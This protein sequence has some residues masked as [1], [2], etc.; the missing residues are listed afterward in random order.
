MSPRPIVVLKPQATAELNNAVAKALE[1]EGYIVFY[2]DDPSYVV[3]RAPG[4]FS[5]A[6]V[7]M[8]R[9]VA[10]EGSKL[11]PPTV[12]HTLLSLAKRIED[13][14]CEAAE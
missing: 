9:D 5:Q 1:Q 7:S 11:W 12:E 13:V 2:S 10:Q 3:V 6:D 4:V 14:V 8:L